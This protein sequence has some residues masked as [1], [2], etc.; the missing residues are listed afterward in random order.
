MPTW[1][2]RPSVPI[3]SYLKSEA[4]KRILDGKRFTAFVVCRRYWSINL[5]AVRKLGSKQGGEYVDGIHFSFAGGQIRSLLS[6]ISYFAKGENRERYL[7]IKIPPSLLKPDYV[8]QA[9]AFANQLADGLE[10]ARTLARDDV[11]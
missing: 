4:V 3:R 9:R 11:G 6:L 5:K 8:D 10:P 1:F 7:G 2:F